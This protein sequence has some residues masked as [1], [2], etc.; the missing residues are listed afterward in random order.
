MIAL[1]LAMRT[2]CL[3]LCHCERCNATRGNPQI[4]GNLNFMDFLL[5]NPLGSSRYALVP[6][7]LRET[8]RLRSH[9]NFWQNLLEMMGK[10]GN[11][12]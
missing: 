3:N 6:H 9:A 2:K 8:L 1:C 10:A 4:K 11:A 5:R 7:S 12:D